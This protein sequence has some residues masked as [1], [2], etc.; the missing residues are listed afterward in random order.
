MKNKVLILISV[1]LISNTPAFSEEVKTIPVTQIKGSVSDYKTE[2]I[3]LNWWEKF[4]DPILTGYIAKTIEANHDVKIAGLRVSQY[5]QLVRVAFGKEFPTLA[6]GTNII[7]QRYSKNY[8]PMLAG[9]MADYTFPLTVSYELDIWK[10][11]WDKAQ[12]EKKQLEAI[13]HDEKAALIS[14]VTEAAS[15][16]VN[17][18][19]T[20]KN[21]ELQNRIVAL[22]SDRLKLAETR[23]N[24]GVAN[25]DEVIARKKDL[26][27]AQIAL[28]EYKKN[29]AVLKSALAV[30]TGES[31][32]NI[33][34]MKFGSIENLENNTKLTDKVSS[35]KILKRPDILKAEAELQK[36]KIDVNIARKAFLPDIKLTGEVGFDSAKFSKSFAGGSFIYLLG[37]NIMETLFTG[38]QRTAMLKAKKYEYDQHFENYQKTLLTSLK[39]VNDSLVII[40]TAKQ[41]DEDLEKKLN[42]EKENLK[43][44]NTRYSVGTISY[45]D[46]LEPKE[47]L[48]SIQKDLI[49]AK[50]NCL[51]DNFGLYKALG[52]NL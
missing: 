5:K 15:V 29:L 24:V 46:T 7:D 22:K 40:K 42:L 20:D 23:F 35:D 3:N 14:I 26:T 4:N 16:Y 13:T 43:L 45:L 49:Q 17:I 30:L 11:N 44:V 33:A 25:S 52:A 27:D 2:I 18:L 6:I 39:E 36:A 50:A 12:S 51:I 10:K 1:L 38:G 34:D 37:A 8:M 9:T 47:K 32:D 48:I 21:I 28:D 19:K 41:K 31:P